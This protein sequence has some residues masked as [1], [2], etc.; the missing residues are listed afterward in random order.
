MVN[1]IIVNNRSESPILVAPRE[2]GVLLKTCARTELYWGD[3]DVPADVA[4]HLFRVA[5]GLESPLLGEQAILGQIKQSYFE[6]RKSGKLSSAINKLFQTASYVG[7]R[8]RTETG[9]ARG[10]VSYSQ[11]TVDILCNELP[12]LGNKVV[13]VIGVNELTESILNFLI[14]RGATNI[15]LANRSFDKAEEIAHKYNNVEAFSLSEKQELFSL[16]DVVIS[17]T[18]APHTIIK[19]SDLPTGKSQLLFDLANPQDIESDVATLEGKR[20]FNLQQIESLAQ[21]NLQKRALE[22]SK[23]EAIIEEEIANLQHWQQYRKKLVG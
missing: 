5:A 22:V 15:L 6:A 14:A 9:I 18:S 23:C 21:Q 10:A 12:D 13:S 1:S 2:D 11:V 17:A 16:S 7:H 19:S 3:G 4:R 8:V 20:V